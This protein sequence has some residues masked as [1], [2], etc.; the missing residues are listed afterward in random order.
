MLPTPLTDA[1]SAPHTALVEIADGDLAFIEAGAQAAAALDVPADRIAGR[2]AQALGFPSSARVQWVQTLL[3]AQEQGGLGQVALAYDTAQE[4]RRLLVTATPTDTPDQFAC[5]IEDATQPWRA[6]EALVHG[7]PALDAM[8]ALQQGGA[9]T[10]GSDL[11]VVAQGGTVPADL[12][13]EGHEATGVGAAPSLVGTSLYDVL[14]KEAADALA[15]ALLAPSDASPST[16][17]LPGE[18]ELHARAVRDDRDWPVAGLAFVQQRTPDAPQ[19]APPPP[20][21]STPE[22]DA[23]AVLSQARVA[24]E[25]AAL[26]DATAALGSSPPAR[27]VR[28]QSEALQATLDGVAAAQQVREAAPDTAP[29]RLDALLGAL[30]PHLEALTQNRGLDL[31]FFVPDQAVWAVGHEAHLRQALLDAV[32]FATTTTPRGAIRLAIREQGNAVAVQ[33]A[34]TGDGLPEHVR[35]ALFEAS[36]PS[37]DG[38]DA[39]ALGLYTA[40]VLTDAMGGMLTAQS[41][42]QRGTLLTFMLPACAPPEEIAGTT[43]TPERPT[44]VLVEPDSDT[45]ALMTLFLRDAWDVFPTDSL[46]GAFEDVL[47]KLATPHADALLLDLGSHVDPEAA[48][49]QLRSHRAFDAAFVIALVASSLPEDRDRHLRLGYDAVL[50]K[51]FSRQAL[52]DVLAPVRG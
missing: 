44:A 49:R 9:F 51:P 50:T 43:T 40:W 21:T 19:E 18:Y 35:A 27:A 47:P 42:A 16:I 24:S 14:P 26:L 45:R 12:H 17:S 6:F 20:A 41:E 22:G 23:L 4:T 11:I 38:L 25:A 46:W 8:A 31:F 30:R 52:L 10:Y 48:I 5:V 36:Q 28:L 2:S 39:S 3:D 33:V 34:D 37:L 32:R 13:P 7:G 15:L 29:L 1:R